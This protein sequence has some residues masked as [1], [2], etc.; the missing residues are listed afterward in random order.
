MVCSH[1]ASCLWRL[2]LFG[3]QLCDLSLRRQ[4]TV[5]RV[6]YAA[7]LYP[8]RVCNPLWSTPDVPPRK[9]EN[10]AHR[11]HSTDILRV[12]SSHMHWRAQD[13]SYIRFPLF[14]ASPCRT[15]TISSNFFPSACSWVVLNA[16]LHL[17]PGNIYSHPNGYMENFLCRGDLLSPISRQ[18]G[19][20]SV[21]C[22]NDA[23]GLKLTNAVSRHRSNVALL[24]RSLMMEIYDP[25]RG[26]NSIPGSS[27]QLE[28]VSWWSTCVDTS[29]HTCCC[30]SC[31]VDRSQHT[32]SLVG[33]P[34]P[35]TETSSIIEN[36]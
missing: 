19:A 30:N 36:G 16:S 14:P 13:A 34:T 33:V 17:V 31:S 20:V 7:G 32:P 2:F 27:R 18:N 8:R 11:I 1:T 10:M 21:R 28:F 15:Q 9:A 6:Y 35:S 23:Q 3:S 25:A 24:L 22:D 29:N 4:S 5:C 12:V 26:G